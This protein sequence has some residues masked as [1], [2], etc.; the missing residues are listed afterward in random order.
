MAD[1]LAHRP[2]TELLGLLRR[3]Q[4]S[5]TELARAYLGRIERLDPELHAYVT[6]CADQALEEARQ[7]DA[8][9]GAGKRL[10]LLH[11]LPVAVKDQMHARG[12]RTT[13]G[14]TIL[15]LVAEE[16]ATVVA[17]LR[18]AGA[19]LLGKL[20]LSEFAFGGNIRH[21][22]G[23]PR[24]PWDLGRQAGHSSSGSGVAVA[25]SLCAAA[26]GEDTGGS[27]RI[28]AAW[29]GVT[30]LRPTWGRVSR[31][32]MLSVCWSMD[33]AGPM[34]RTVEDCALVFQAIAG[35]D[36]QDPYTVRGRVPRFRPRKGLDGLRAGIIREAMSSDAVH[37][38]VREAV[39]R[40][41]SALEESGA[42]VWE[43]SI[44][45]AL[46]AGVISAT[47]TDAEGSYLHRHWLRSRPGDYDTVTRRRLLAG[48]LLSSQ[49]YQKA[50][51]LR[52]VMRRQVLAALEQADVLLSPT[53]PVAA[54]RMEASS[55]LNSKEDVLARFAGPRGATAPFNL[56]AVPALSVPCGFTGE[57]LPIGLQIAGRPFD[58]LAVLQVG[59]AYQQRTDWHTRRP[60]L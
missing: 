22:Y 23:T 1:D 20:N 25:A 34:T 4:V 12:L 50:L 51:R 2:A 39:E 18:Q 9:L 3:R 5:A 58:E 41:A 55:G 19:V 30:G 32:G 13:G 6:V 49:L 10:G 15:D 44:P 27:I 54:P 60:P 16:D 29:C 48:S 42:E 43:V 47:I 36:P 33:Q 7:A 21:P 37:P 35:Q 24:N 38:E 57:G 52:V 28:P 14:S 31:Y 45:L 17:R 59:H 56:S 46:H 26:I 8:A 40:A 53:Q 11:G